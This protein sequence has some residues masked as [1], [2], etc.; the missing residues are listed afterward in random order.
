MYL[1]KRYEASGK[2][3]SNPDFKKIAK[4]FNINYTLIK[5]H[6]NFKNLNKVISSKKP[7]I[8]EIKL[9]NDQKIIPKLQFGNPIEDLSP[10]LP[11]KE[12]Y[13][14]M[15]ISLVKRNKKIFEAN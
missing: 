5:S 2:G 15:D 8:I 6:L 14:N 13:K 9:K 11:R 1:G 10:L 4:A 3:V 12:F 7:E